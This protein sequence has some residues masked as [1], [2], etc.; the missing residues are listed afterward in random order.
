MRHLYIQPLYK[1]LISDT[2]I[3]SLYILKAYEYRSRLFKIN[4][5]YTNN[6]HTISKY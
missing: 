1:Y 3:Y 4:V 6:Q 5:N 2:I